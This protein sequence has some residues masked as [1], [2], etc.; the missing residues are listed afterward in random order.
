MMHDVTQVWEV[1]CAGCDIAIGKILGGRFIH[2]PSCTLPRRI[3]G[4]SFKCCRCGGSLEGEKRPMPEPR[5]SLTR[6][7]AR[8]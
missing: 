8:R 5:P 6:I 7:G 4:G 2:D 1:R 3:E